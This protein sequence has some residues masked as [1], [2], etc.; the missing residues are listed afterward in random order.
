MKRSCDPGERPEGVPS[1]DDTLPGRGAT[2]NE[3]GVPARVA[4]LARRAI[5]TRA[6]PC[7]A[8]PRQW[9]PD[10]DEIVFRRFGESWLA[11]PGLRKRLLAADDER[12]SDIIV[13]RLGLPALLAEHPR[14]LLLIYR[15]MISGFVHRLHRRREECPDIVQEIY[16]RLLAGKL[17]QIQKKFDA[18]FGPAPSF[19]SYFMV[20]VRNMYIDVVR[21]GRSLMM[22]GVEIPM[23][24]VAGDE[25]SPVQ[26]LRS[27]C[28]DEEFAKLQ[29]ILQLQPAGRER[30]L[31]CLKL[32]CRLPV[33]AADVRR[34]FPGCSAEDISLLGADYR[35]RRDRDMYRAVVAAF[36]RNEAR[37]VKADTLRKWVENKSGQ[38]AVHMN[39]LHR[40][41][42]YDSE[43]ISD[44]IA[45]FI[46]REE[47]HGQ[48]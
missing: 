5:A 41:D 25:L 37:P 47:S 24:A 16:A 34:C 45:L 32:K 22:K 6:Y 2:G 23:P 4:G 12:A 35:S 33:S 7:A 26:A 14:S 10:L 31:L 42:V 28:L 18:G 3:Q 27:A 36:N 39:R 15:R 19:T 30:I 40:E 17:F 20:C 38:L 48:G 8:Y 1:T 21:E 44:L 29:A 43:N 13:A 46:A 11:E 9:F